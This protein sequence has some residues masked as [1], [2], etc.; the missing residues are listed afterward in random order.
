[1]KNKLVLS[2]CSIFIIVIVSLSLTTCD[3]LAALLGVEDDTT[4][5][6]PSTEQM[7]FALKEALTTGSENAGATLSVRGAFFNNAERKIPL[8]AEAQAILTNLNSIS[9]GSA[10]ISAI[11]G[12]KAVN[13]LILRINSAAEDASKDVGGIF[14]NAV[15]SM[16]FA[17]AAAILKGNDTEATDYLK[18]TTTIPL[19]AS[20]SPVLNTALDTPIVGNISALSAWN[21]VIT[22]YNDFLKSP[23]TQIAMIAL[24]VNWQPVNTNLSEFVLDKALT[25]VFNEI[26]VMEKD[27]R[28]DPLQFLSDISTKV[29]DWAK[30][31]ISPK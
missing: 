1:M 23:L 18:S 10:I 8:P 20:F 17:D 29:F 31:L 25:A 24:G 11:G 4:A 26:A 5:F 27:I 7:V 12:D 6:S 28:A 14:G 19:T 9:G 30:D 16:T 13:D 22:P 3:L 21:G 2:I 15:K